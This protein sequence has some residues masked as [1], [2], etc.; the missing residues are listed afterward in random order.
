[1]SDKTGKSII[2]TLVQK[3]EFAKLI[4]EDHGIGIP[5]EALVRIFD[6]FERAVS[7]DEISG[8][9][10]GLFISQEIVKSHSG[11]IRGESEFGKGSKF[12]AE[13]PI[14]T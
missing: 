6:R 10:L 7:S 2:I 1:V 8:L 3:G 14:N 9:G 4:I 5:R 11:K 13:L 12:I